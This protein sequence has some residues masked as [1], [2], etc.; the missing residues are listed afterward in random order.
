MLVFL[1]PLVVF[2]E[3]ALYFTENNIQI[4]AHDHL[5]K[6]FEYFDMP[7]TQG[8][9][10]GGFIIITILLLWHLF[11]ASK[12]M[13]EFRVIVFMAIESVLFAIPLLVF[14]G[15]LGGL[16]VST[17]GSSIGKLELF[18]KLAVSIGAGL[19]EELVFRMLL[20]GF[21]HTVA[22]SIF[23]QKDHIGLIAGIIV[24]AVLFALYHD[25]PTAGSL[26]ELSLFFFF[27][28]GVYL[29][30][31]FVSRGFGIAAATH[32]AYDVVATSILASI[33]T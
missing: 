25:L 22:C 30:I 8:L 2:Y 29:G 23:K 15:F 12:W 24:S 18:D 17:N 4:K 5:L 3:V 9:G 1:L 6:F 14:G 27:S 32:A 16:A 26:P 19:Y 11:N 21:V 33:A 20:I 10:I 7:P 31:L 13:V 28:A